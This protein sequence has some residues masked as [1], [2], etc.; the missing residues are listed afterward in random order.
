MNTGTRTPVTA[1]RPASQTRSPLMCRSLFAMH[2]GHH[3][4]LRLWPVGQA[5]DDLGT[6]CTQGVIRSASSAAVGRSE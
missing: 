6:V 4:R 5:G 2:L 1:Q 3:Q